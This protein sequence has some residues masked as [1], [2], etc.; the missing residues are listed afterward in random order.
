VVKKITAYSF[1]ILANIILLAHAVIPHH[2]HESVVC[3]E[4]K[5]CQDDEIPLHHNNS[6]HEH[7]HDGNEN[8]NCCILKQYV[9]TPSF[10]GKQL[11]SCDNC[12]DNHNHDYYTLS[13]IGYCDLQPV[14]KVVTYYPVHSSYLLSFVTSTLGLRAPPT[15]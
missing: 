6:E 7:Q 15:V 4:Q 3:V 13:N 8:S 10:Q 1:L 14:S 9:V 11:R 12:S 5:H 2:H